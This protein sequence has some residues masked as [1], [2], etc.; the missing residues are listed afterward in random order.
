MLDLPQFSW[1]LRFETQT[2]G[3]VTFA[4]FEQGTSGELLASAAVVASTPRGQRIDDESFGV[5][6]LVFQAGPVDTDRLSSELQQA[7]D[8]LD[9]QVDELFDVADATRRHVTIRPS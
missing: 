9:L 7:D 2:D 3:T 6:E 8:R 4:E 1:P 5:S